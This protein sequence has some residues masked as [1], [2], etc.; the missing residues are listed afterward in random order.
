MAGILVPAIQLCECFWVDRINGG[1]WS[2]PLLVGVFAALRLGNIQRLANGESVWH[3][4]I[5]SLGDAFREDVPEGAGDAV[6]GIAALDGVGGRMGHALTR[7]AAPGAAGGD[8]EGGARADPGILIQSVHAE[9]GA[10][11]NVEPARQ[12][13]GEFTL[14]EDV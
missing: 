7:G 1:Y 10:G 2:P 6:D 14:L 8:G 4:H 11:V 9:Q 12:A 3:L 13:V 5:V